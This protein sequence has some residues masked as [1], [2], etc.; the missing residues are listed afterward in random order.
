MNEKSR[1]IKRGQ[2]LSIPEAAGEAGVSV[3]T[4][5]RYQA[6]GRLKV[7]RIAGRVYC[8]PA[9]LAAVLTHGSSS[10]PLTA[11]SHPHWESRAV[12]DWMEA[13]R[14]QLIPCGGSAQV[15]AAR[16]AIIAAIDGDHGGLPVPSFRVRHLRESNTRVAAR[17]RSA[18]EVATLLTLPEATVVIEGWR[19]VL[20]LFAGGDERSG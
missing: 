10:A 18:P 19:L 2:L 9:S 3:R 17:G 11:I 4:L 12:S 1:L 20:R 16:R 15:Q 5:R 7:T 8:S 13:W 14:R 6:A